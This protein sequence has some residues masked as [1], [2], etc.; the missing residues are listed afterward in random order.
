[1]S[2]VIRSRTADALSPLPQALAD[3]V[4]AVA[5]PLLKGDD[6]VLAEKEAH[7]LEG[8]M[9][10]QRFRAADREGLARRPTA[11][12]DRKSTGPFGLARAGNHPGYPGF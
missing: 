11:R 4:Q 8:E 3:V 7:L 5:G 6:E 2:E 1:M 9:L 12:V 10:A